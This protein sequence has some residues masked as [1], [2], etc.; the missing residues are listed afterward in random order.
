M[1]AALQ[2]GVLHRYFFYGWLFHDACRGNV[3][4]RAQALRHNREQSRWLPTYLRRWLATGAMS[5]GIAVVAEFG[6]G[7]PL[8]AA[9]FYAHLALVAPFLAVTTLAWFA[10]QPGRASG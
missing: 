8:L 5:L 6:L 3:W 10:L 2:P 7:S 1:T 4:E 9:V